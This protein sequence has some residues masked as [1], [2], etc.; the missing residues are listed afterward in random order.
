MFWTNESHLRGKEN[1]MLKMMKVLLILS[2]ISST[3]FAYAENLNPSARVDQ[4][5]EARQQEFARRT[6]LGQSW[7]EIKEKETSG[8]EDHESSPVVSFLIGQITLEGKPEALDFLEDKW[9]FTTPRAMTMKGINGMAERLNR[10][11]L[12][13]G[14]VTSRI[15]IPEQNIS[16]G[17]LTLLFLPGRI[18]HIYCKEGSPDIPW[19]N[20]FPISEGDLLNVRLLE[21]G[22]EQ[23]KRVSSLDISMN[24]IPSETE[25]MTDVELSIAKGKQ[26]HGALSLDDS[27]LKETG[28]LQ[29]NLDLGIDRLFNANDIFRYSVSLDGERDGHERN[30]KS[31]S[32]Y[33][34]IPHG[35]DTFSISHT[36]N[37]YH[38]TAASRPFPLNYS[39]K[40]HLTRFT[41]DHMISRSRTE[42][43]DVDIS[44]IKRNTHT[45]LND[46]EIPLQEI[47][48]SA[49]EIGLSDR[50]YA[51]ESTL[52]G[53]LAYR[54]GMGW[55]GSKAENGYGDGPT[56]RYRMW[57]MDMDYQKPFHLGGRP[58]SFTASFH[59]QWTA[60]GERLHGV[61]MISLGN[62]YTVRGFDGEYTLM[63]ESG[64]FMRN[65]L[66]ST[67]PKLKS[68]VY[69]GLDVG[70]VYG[71]S[72]ENLAGKTLAGMALGIRGNMTNGL[73]YDA[74]ISHS[75]YKPEGM[76]TKK[77]PA[78]FMAGYRF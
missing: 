68:S 72:A 44:I 18:H 37:T 33:Y 5:E 49:L 36:Y 47:D 52:Y 54:K 51:G 71:P 6:R 41:Y 13:K 15:V 28:R 9:H 67:L 64:W 20:A 45:Y 17:R 42:K 75:L 26:L 66:E 78:G 59:G 69:L 61:D 4:L 56:T 53:R 65:E 31:Q 57:L 16:V 24:L 25:G 39:G 40:T 58:S 63:T 38:E 2:V 43:R 29:W 50:V 10:K 22:L 30:S 48:S 7:I 74:F 73:F 55:L 32:M 8:K 34:S 11:L 46:T 21:Q 70:A 62:R 27:G 35:K 77:W 19:R 76:H 14:Y 23:M 12:D 3:G 60:Q 1:T